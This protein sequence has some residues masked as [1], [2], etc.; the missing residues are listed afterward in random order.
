[1]TEY[2]RGQGS[3][4]WHPEDP[5]YGDDGWGGQQAQQPPYGGRPQHYPQQPQ[6]QAQYG[7]WGQGGQP[8]YGAG[9]QS[10]PQ[11]YDGQNHPQYDGQGQQGQQGYQGGWDTGA[12][13][14][15]GMHGAPEAH[16]IQGQPQAQYPADP[17]DPYGNQAGAY[18]A[19]QPDRYGTSDAYPPPEQPGRRRTEPEP[20]ETDWDPGPD[21]GEHAFFAG[22][23]D[24]EDDDVDSDGG[25]GGRGGRGDRRGRGGKGAKAGKGGKK[26]RS[27]CACLVVVLVLGGGV[28]GVGYFGYQFYQDRFGAAPDYA[29]EGTDKTVTVTISQGASGYTIGQELKKADVVKSVDAFV[30]AQANNPD[31]DK[32]QAGVYVLNTQMS[33]ANAVSLMLDPKSRNNLVIAEGQR[34]AQIYKAIDKRLELKSGTTESVAEDKWSQLGLPEWANDDKDI[35]DPLEGFLYPS[36]YPVAK[37]MKPED[38]L[39]EMVN[40]S[41]Q[42]YAEFGL[43]KKAQSLDLEDPLQVLTVASLVQAEGKYKHDFEKVARVIYNRLEPDNTETYGLLDFD[44]TVNYLRGESKLA[45]GPVDDLRQI[46]DPYNTYKIRGLPPGPIGNPGEEAI[47]ASL[48]PAEGDWYYFVSISEDETLFAV[49]NEEHNRNREKYEEAQNGQ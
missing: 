4:P 29:G 36:S 16:G 28:G 42:K 5:L 23:D 47:K 17:T 19:E 46:N 30:T 12:H 34:N 18:G 15:D 49:T 2:G 9:Q 14:F 38:V 40:L 32:I 1:M 3:E 22:G 33:A 44:S 10:Y 26:R 45:T 37:G 21:Q 48:E 8:G 31:G 35:K 20:R 11:Q 13:A 25:P 7:D 6:Q 43:E 39:K 24:D 27:G 41:K